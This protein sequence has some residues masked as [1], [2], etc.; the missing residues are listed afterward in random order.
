MC[1]IYR[2]WV[3]KLTILEFFARLIS[4][5][6]ETTYQ[7]S[8]IYIRCTLAA[9]FVAVLISDLAECQPFAHYWQVLPD[10]GGRCRQ[11]YAQLLTMAV[12][13]VL[14]DLLLVFFPIPIILSSTMTVKRKVEL[15][16]LFSLSLGVVGVTLYRVPHIIW[17]Q[18]SQQL[19]S[20]LASVELL[21]AAVAANSLVLG[22]FVRDRGIKKQRFK[23]GSDGTA[24]ATTDGPPPDS[25]RPTVLRHWGSDEDLVRDLGLGVHPELREMPDSPG[26]QNPHFTPAPIVRK[27]SGGLYLNEW[28][29]PR[30]EQS[31]T[32]E[33]RSD[34][35]LLTG[36]REGGVSRRSSAVTPRRVSFFDVGGLLDE[37]G[38]ASGAAREGNVDG[39]DPLSGGAPGS[40][41]RGS[42]ALLQDLGGFF[43]PSFTRPGRSRSKTGTELQPIPQSSH[44]MELREAVPRQGSGTEAASGSA[45]PSTSTASGKMPNLPD[46]GGSPK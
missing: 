34:D 32:A 46:A 30:P 31:G 6:W 26:I 33:E 35:T 13:N 19:R 11:G 41:R 28:Q 1:K 2:L 12:C 5:T 9:T 8:L 44:E 21:F 36:D 16:L 18:G 14:T 45:G 22:S 43:T 23:Y 39:M 20:L 29:F 38:A 37:P 17:S 15:T 10:P 40:G 7:T 3:F 4:V 42:A 25:R 24:S 27:L